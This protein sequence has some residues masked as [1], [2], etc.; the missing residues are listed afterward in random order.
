MQGGPDYYPTREETIAYLHKY[1]KKYKLNIQRPV[2]VH[3][4][5]K[6]PGG[7]ILENI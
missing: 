1:E 6:L 7:F 3:G 2:K 4:V 5:N